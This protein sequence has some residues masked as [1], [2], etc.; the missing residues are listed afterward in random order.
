M[1][2]WEAPSESKGIILLTSVQEFAASAA[3]LQHLRTQ[4]DL[5]SVPIV[6]L[7]AHV[8]SEAPSDIIAAQRDL[9]ACGADEVAFNAPS[10][11]AIDL[12]MCIGRA[13]FL[14]RIHSFELS[15]TGESDLGSEIS[16]DL[17]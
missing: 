13:R 15:S 2:S 12:A 5:E 14:R 4:P 1:E 8:D 6:A 16:W 10:E 17:S 3:C 7:L 11:A 9:L